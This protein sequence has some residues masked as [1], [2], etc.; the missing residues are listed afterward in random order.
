MTSLTKTWSRT[1]IASRYLNG[2]SGQAG[3]IKGRSRPAAIRS[4]VLVRGTTRRRRRRRHISRDTLRERDQA[5]RLSSFSA[6]VGELFAAVH[7]RLQRPARTLQSLWVLRALRL[8]SLLQG[9]AAN[10]DIAGA[11]PDCRTSRCERKVTSRKSTSIPP[12]SARPASPMS[13]LPAREFFQPADLVILSSF[14][15]NNVRMM[16]LSGIGK[17]YDPPP[18]PA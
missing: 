11:V 14:Q 15:T 3:N 18:A 1:S 2:A 7:Q 8:L 17:P 6:T 13:M 12:A 4:R 10:D 16:L 5:T 9:V